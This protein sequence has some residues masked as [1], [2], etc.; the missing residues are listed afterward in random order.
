MVTYFY[1]RYFAETREEFL[2]CLPITVMC[3]S[4]FTILAAMLCG[5]L[6]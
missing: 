3:D 6:L 4:L 1:S 2:N 5:I